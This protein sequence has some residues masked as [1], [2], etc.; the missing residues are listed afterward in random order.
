M[1]KILLRQDLL[2][3]TA[4]APVDNLSYLM[5][6]MREMHETCLY[7]NGIGLAASQIGLPF[8]FFVIARSKEIVEGYAN[9][10][11]EPVGNEKGVCFEG[12]LSLP[13]RTFLVERYMSVHV[14]GSK[15]TYQSEC[16][17]SVDMIVTDFDA[18]VFQHEIDHQS[19][20]AIDDHGKEF[21]M[22]QLPRP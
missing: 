9:C 7:S 21:D 14:K 2:P 4:D 18:V 1:F 16:V 5:D 6:V 8:K 15:I 10:E 19:N 22:D 17:E 13:S 11:Y 12:C 3:S 20:I